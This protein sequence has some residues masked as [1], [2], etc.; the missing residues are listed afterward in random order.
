MEF[1]K[2]K[3]FT[4]VN[5]DELKIGANGFFA[6]NIH[7]LKEKVR[8]NEMCHT[9]RL[10]RIKSSHFEERFE[11]DSD[12][13][14]SYCLFY[15]VD[16]E[17]PQEPFYRPYESTDE[18]ISDF[19]ERFK[20]NVPE[21]GIPFIWVKNEAKQSQLVTGFSKNAIESCGS[22]KLDS[23]FKRFTYLDGTPCGL[24]ED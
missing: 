14:S 4:A 17:E 8:R 16:S 13:E 3:V 23:L 20:V 12:L 11:K 1:D 10:K 9:S 18:M 21:Y 7:E 19:K 22:I 15:L 24:L 6:N 2:T 5:A